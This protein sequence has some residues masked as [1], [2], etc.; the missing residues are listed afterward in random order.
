MS[1]LTRQQRK[2]ASGSVLALIALAL[3][4][5]YLFYMPLPHSKIVLPTSSITVGSTTILAE[6][7]T[8]QAQREQGLSGRVSLNPGQGMLFVF[9]TPGKWGIWMKDM[10]FSID[11]IW[12]D[13]NG[14][15]V[16][17]EPDVSPDTYPSHSFYPTQAATYVL[18][19]PAGYTKAKGIAVGTKIVLK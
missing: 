3:V 12:A 14:K 19:V 11:I 5:A 2:F 18:E 13:K 15:I 16:T 7:A 10:R 1:L 6:L 4:C 8:T 17:I 9:A